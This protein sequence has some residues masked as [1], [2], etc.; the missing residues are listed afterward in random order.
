MYRSRN[1][2]FPRCGTDRWRYKP[3]GWRPCKSRFGKCRSA[4]SRCRRCRQS[5]WTSTDWSTSRCRYRRSRLG[6]TGRWPRRSSA[7][8]RCM[9]R[10]GKT[11]PRCRHCHRRKTYR[12]AWHHRQ[13][14]M[15]LRRSRSACLFDRVHLAPDR[16]AHRR[17]TNRPPLCKRCHRRNRFPHRHSHCPCTQQ[18]PSRKT[19]LPCDMG[20]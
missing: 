14:T 1:R 2:R 6:G 10:C 20:C 3:R 8:R 13:R 7:C 4:C 5:H 17:K 19:R 18:H 16:S 11:R 12:R 9:C 15:R